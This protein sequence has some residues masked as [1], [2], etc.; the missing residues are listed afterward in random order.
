[1]AALENIWHHRKVAETSSKSCFICYKPSS[2][3]LITPDS[4]DYFYVCPSHL[5]DKNFAVATDDEAKAIE[6]R[7]KQEE[8]NKEIENIKKEYEDKMK[9]KEEKHKE[10]DKDKAKDDKKDDAKAKDEQTDAQAEK[11][12]D[13]KV[14]N[15][16]IFILYNR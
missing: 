2:S 7:K 14:S 9:R 1:M 11:E 15:T 6:E 10:K 12:K 3:V 8:L 16:C 4:K 13:D 5:K